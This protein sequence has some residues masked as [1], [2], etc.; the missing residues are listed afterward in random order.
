[1]KII[2]FNRDVYLSTNWLY[3]IQMLQVWNIYL[4]LAWFY[5]K[6]EAGN[7]SSPMEHVGDGSSCSLTILGIS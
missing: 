6:C 7:Y 3:L 1:M 5:G 4:H 2:Y